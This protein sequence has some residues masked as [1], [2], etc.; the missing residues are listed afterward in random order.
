MVRPV[1]DARMGVRSRE[2]RGVPG[3]PA[4]RLGDAEMGGAPVIFGEKEDARS[5]AREGVP[6]CGDIGDC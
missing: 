5:R 2:G 4:G 6:E 1:G 3:G